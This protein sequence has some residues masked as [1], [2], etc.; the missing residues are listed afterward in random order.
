M[1]GLNFGASLLTGKNRRHLLAMVSAHQRGWPPSTTRV[2]AL[3]LGEKES[4]GRAAAAFICTTPST[5]TTVLRVLAEAAVV[6]SPFQ[7]LCMSE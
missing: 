2:G 4:T 5:A 7:E 3:G 1:V 6:P